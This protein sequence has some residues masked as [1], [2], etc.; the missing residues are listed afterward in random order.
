MRSG[1][2]ADLHMLWVAF[3]T[4]AGYFVMLG[5][6]FTVREA[7]GKKRTEVFAIRTG[8]ARP[9]TGD[10]HTLEMTRVLFSHILLGLPRSAIAR[11]SCYSLTRR[12]R[13]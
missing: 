1:V 3:G 10:P 7:Q 13:N 11:E 8:A 9:V 4:L 5:T 12:I 6:L 2:D